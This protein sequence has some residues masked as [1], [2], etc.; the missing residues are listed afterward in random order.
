MNKRQFAR[1]GV[2]GETFGHLVNASKQSLSNKNLTT[3]HR[4]ALAKPL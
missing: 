1:A 4:Q 2:E 3:T